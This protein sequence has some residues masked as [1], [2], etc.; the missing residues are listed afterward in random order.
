MSDETKIEPAMSEADWAYT[1]EEL[2][3]SPP[4]ANGKR[5]L[6][7]MYEYVGATPRDNA[8]FIAANNAALPDDDPRKITRERLNAIRVILWNWEGERSG[9][10]APELRFM[11]SLESYLPPEGA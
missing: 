11:D 9:D 8:E 6:A 3:A 4:D 7:G 5:Y 2:A 1:L 10:A